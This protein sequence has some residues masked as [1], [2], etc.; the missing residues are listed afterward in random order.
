MI[1]SESAH[2]SRHSPPQPVTL[3][4]GYISSHYTNATG[5]GTFD[6]PWR[7]SL[8]EGF[9]V[10]VDL[11]DFSVGQRDRSRFTGGVSKSGICQVRVYWAIGE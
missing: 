9:K 5:C 7:I 11:L 8:P 6:T 10:K 3:T 4:T 2:C 1:T